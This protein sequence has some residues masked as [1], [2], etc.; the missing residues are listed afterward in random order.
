MIDF[1]KL[2]DQHLIKKFRPKQIGRYY[3]SGIGDCIRKTW[4]SYKIP[5]PP[6]PT[7]MRI[8][9]AGNMLHDFMTEVMASKKNAEVE[10]LKSEMPIFIKK[11]GYTISGRIDNLVLLKVDDKKVLVEVKSCK[12]LPEEPKA[13]NIM[14]L[15]FYMY[16]TKTW[17]GSLV[18]VQKDNLQTKTFHIRCKKET[19]HRI[20]KR[21][22]DLHK[23]LT[24]ETIPYPEAKHSHK[25]KHLC[26][27]C[28]WKEE[29]FQ[30]E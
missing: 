25:R 17:D 6:E 1:N 20:L 26:N 7:L 22:E 12:N 14:Q 27:F 5:K 18:Y 4:F 13:E 28:P 16:A 23:H 2:I 29:C 24:E 11:P 10:L 21:F 15:Q 3:P 8:F 9:A 30:Y 19:A